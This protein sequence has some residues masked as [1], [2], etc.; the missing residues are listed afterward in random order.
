MGPLSV[1]RRLEVGIVSTIPP[2]EALDLLDPSWVAALRADLA[3]I[4]AITK[5]GPAALALATNWSNHSG[6]WAE[7]QVTKFGKMV[8][9]CGLIKC[10]V[11]YTPSTSTVATVPTGYRP[12]DVGATA[13]LGGN[14]MFNGFVSTS[15][16]YRL[17]VTPTGLLRIY[18][19]PSAISANALVGFVAAWMTD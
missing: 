11:S 7:A 5:T 13:P 17:E 2:V 9:C 6:G 19:G 15:A 18:A 14:V 4:N 8:A 10:S 1:L 3:G 12:R 16:L